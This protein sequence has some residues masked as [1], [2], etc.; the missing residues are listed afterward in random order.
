LEVFAAWTIPNQVYF[1][2][3]TDGGLTWESP[4]QIRGEN[5]NWKRFAKVDADRNGRVHLIWSEVGSVQ[6]TTSATGESGTWTTPD[7]AMNGNNYRPTLFVDDEHVYIAAKQ[8]IPDRMELM[9]RELVGDT[10]YGPYVVKTSIQDEKPSYARLASDSAGRLFIIYEDGIS[11]DPN[12]AQFFN[13]DTEY[14]KNRV[15]LCRR[16]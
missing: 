7:S 8:S 5:G 10:W 12:I 6:Y 11:T 2:R 3:S 9:R 16:M 15:T 14:E 1:A 4:V 13:P